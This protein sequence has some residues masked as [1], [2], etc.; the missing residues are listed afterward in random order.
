VLRVAPDGF[1]LRET[2]AEYVQLVD[3]PA[4]E[5]ERRKLEK[6]PGMRPDERVRLQGAGALVFDEYGALKYHVANPISDRAR[7][8][9]RIGHLWRSGAF[10]DRRE[11]RAFAT[12]HRAA[13]WPLARPLD[14]EEW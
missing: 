13:H 3:L 12:L 1:F 9:A 7:Q 6:P 5:L 2:V 14:G 11:P 4:R 10:R 8:A